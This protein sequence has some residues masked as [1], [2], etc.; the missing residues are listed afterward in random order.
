[1]NKL[2]IASK[3]SLIEALMKYLSDS[4]QLTSGDMGRTI[5]LQ[6]NQGKGGCFPYHYG[7]YTNASVLRVLCLFLLID[8]PGLPNKRCLTCI[9]YLNLNW[10][11][12]DGGELLLQ[13]FLQPTISIQP[14]FDRLVIFKSN[15]MLHRVE[16]TYKERFCCTFW[17][18]G[19]GTNSPENTELRLAKSAIEDIDNTVKML[20]KSPLQRS[21]SR[22]VYQ[23]EYEESLYDCMEG[24]DGCDEMI[25]SH[26][27]HVK[28]IDNNIPLRN[29]VEAL[30]N[31]RTDHQV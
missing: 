11:V 25:A 16:K 19:D 9:L 17:I 26:I 15:S 4:M 31:W 28:S 20:Q 8:N 2:F 27:F 14:L 24:S 23:E 6:H 5:K 1:M 7:I 18:D 22:F 10:K 30:R 3:S 13:P 12:G 21:L 29:L